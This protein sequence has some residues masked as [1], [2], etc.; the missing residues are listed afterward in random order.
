MFDR[1][2]FLRMAI[3]AALSATVL[4]AGAASSSPD[5]SLRRNSALGHFHGGHYHGA[6]VG[7]PAAKRNAMTSKYFGST[8][9][10]AGPTK[11]IGCD[12]GSRPEKVQGKVPKADYE[13]GR[14]A[15]GYSCNARRVSQFGNSGGYRVERYVDKAGHECAYWDSTLL[16]PHNAPDQGTE[17]PG[18][19]VMAG[20]LP[21]TMFAERVAS[22]C[23]GV[24]ERIHK[25]SCVISTASGERSTP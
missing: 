19:Y 13:S 7:G 9:P 10:Y 12:N 18:L 8:K 1:D 2:G 6:T 3:A 11:G 21:W 22:V 14:A 4:A 15:K 17:G 24:A 20:I 5:V 25:A 16:W 23:P